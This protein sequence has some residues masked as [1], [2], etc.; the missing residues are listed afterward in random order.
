MSE[1][2]QKPKLR[3][4]EFKDEWIKQK[5]S[6]RMEVFRGAS[7]RPKGDPK[8]YGGK[9][10][11]LMIEDATR[12]GKYV[13]PS[14]DSLTLDGAKKSRFLVKGNVVLSCSGTNV[15]I[16]TILA[17]DACIHDGWLGFKNLKEVNSEFLYYL[18]LRL[19][20]KMQGEATTGGVFNNLTTSIL[21]DLKLNFTG[22]N[23]QI[24][25]ASFLREVDVKTS[26]LKNKIS[27]LEQYKKGIMQLLFS[28]ELRFK[29][30]V[31]NN[32]TNWEENSIGNIFYSEKGNGIPKGELTEKGKRKCILYGELYTK[33]NEVIFDVESRTN[34][35]NG[36]DSKKGDLLIPSSTTTTGIDLANVTALNFENVKIGGDIIVLRSNQKINNVF[37]AYYLSNFKKYKIASRAQ[38]ITIVHLYFSSIKD[39]VIDVPSLDEQTKIA[40]FLS[41]I[42]DKI[43]LVNTQLENTQQFKKGLLQQMFV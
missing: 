31:G 8:Y 2:I 9:V 19:Y 35:G 26:R 28:Q 5:L 41:V 12:D 15:A 40:N 17:V 10:P 42:D 1:F 23:E 39:I 24:K 34:S 16:P 36:L 3:F 37:Y 22:L 20:E 7:P 32:Y 33:Y 30:E 27:L 4:Q 38:G 43:R 29:N 13:Y 14:I 6:S 18:F 21:R 25:I 11:R